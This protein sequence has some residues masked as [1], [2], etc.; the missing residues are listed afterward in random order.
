[1]EAQAILTETEDRDPENF[2]AY[3]KVRINFTLLKNSNGMKIRFDTENMRTAN[4]AF[5]S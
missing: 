5:R 1:M 3:L 2:N 4:I